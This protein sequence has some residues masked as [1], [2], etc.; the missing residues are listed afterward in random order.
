[1][2]EQHKK[3]QP[4]TPPGARSRDRLDPEDWRLYLKN[5]G[6]LPSS[7]R[8]LLDTVREQSKDA[9]DANREGGST[10]DYLLRKKMDLIEMK[11]T[12][13]DL[14]RQEEE[15]LMAMAD[16][17]IHLAREK[18]AENRRFIAALHQANGKIILTGLGVV[19]ATVGAVGIAAVAGPEGLKQVGQLLPQVAQRAIRK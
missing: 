5:A 18:E 6:D 17:L 10:H 4:K 1:M 12:K 8:E 15:H 9:L 3:Q 11:L 7:L 13:P 19:A 2:P 14:T 16:E